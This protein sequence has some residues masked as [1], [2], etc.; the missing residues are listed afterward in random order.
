MTQKRYKTSYEQWIQIEN[1]FPA[2][3]TGRPSKDNR[4]MFNSI[5]WI[6]RN[7]AEWRDD[8]TLLTIF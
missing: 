4:L 1:L 2:A 3:K 8:C 6:A 5:L 7:G